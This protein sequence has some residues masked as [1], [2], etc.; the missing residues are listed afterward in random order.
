MNRHL[1]K[2]LIALA[3]VAVAYLLV[4]YFALPEYWARYVRRHPAL[5]AIPGIT[6]TGNGMPGDPLNVSL[7]G[8]ETELKKIM[9]AASWLPADPLTLHSCLEIAEASV[10]KRAYDEAPVSNLFLFDRKQDLAFERPVHNN[11]RQRHHVRFWK[12]DNTADGRPVWVGAAIYDDRVGIN[13]E[14]GQVTHHTA[15]NID[16]ERDQLFHDLEATGDLV[17]VTFE[18]DFHIVREGK[19]GGGDPWT[20][21]GRLELGTIKSR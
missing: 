7:I 16:A 15:A 11:P 21:D 14:T 12:S 4:S 18:D 17:E 20:T 2:A 10:L 1:R 19:N 13:R 5:N 8:T 6:H 3:S 9:L